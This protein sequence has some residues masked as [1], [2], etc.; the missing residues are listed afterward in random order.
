[1]RLWVT[2]LGI[3]AWNTPSW[4]QGTETSPPTLPAGTRARVHAPLIPIGGTT[5]RLLGQSQDTVLFRPDHRSYVYRLP[6]GSIRRLD[7]VVGHRRNTLVGIAIGGF[8]GTGLGAGAGLSLG[9][10]DRGHDSGT[11]AALG[12]GVAVLLGAVFGTLHR[13][14][15]WA[16]YNQPVRVAAPVTGE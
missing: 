5:G 16:P 12:A 15:E 2:L 6:V 7:L 13:T 11:G 14:S 3:L 1:M 9:Q 4:A 10:G 8:L